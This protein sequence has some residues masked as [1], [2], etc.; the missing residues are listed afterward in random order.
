MDL[1]PLEIPKI[2]QRHN[3]TPKKSLGQNF[4]LDPIALSWVANSAGIEPGDVV[5]EV[6]PGLGSLTRYLAEQAEKVVA[7]ELD[8]RLISPLE[9]IL[10]PYDNVRVVQGNVLEIPPGELVDAPDYLVVGNIP[11]YITSHL[12]RHLLEARLPP[13]R[14][15][16]TMQQEVA[17]RICAAPGDMSILSLSVQVYG[18]P[19]IVALIE[20]Y[21]FYPAPQ[22]NS[23]ILRVDMYPE[24]YVP[25]EDLDTF[26]RLVKAGFS[27]R[28]KNLRNAISGGMRWSKAE[29]VEKLEAAGIDPR[30]R[31]ENLSL[32]EWR[33]L[34]EV[35][36]A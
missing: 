24:P 12:I 28:R 8:E 35:V 25:E 22:V 9:E 29:A 7:V 27:Q 6:G 13:Q 16:L 5:L 3:I 20:P 30:R 23:A 4:L 26:F 18:R 31:A 21:F 32:D 1:P 2:L 34:T 14:M 17:E 33:R 19:F 36:A 11:Y 10:E 15:V